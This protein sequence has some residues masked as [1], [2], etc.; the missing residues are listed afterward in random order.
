LPKGEGVLQLPQFYNIKCFIKMSNIYVIG[1]GIGG[2]AA[3]LRLRARG[4]N[5]TILEKCADAGGRARR[6]NVGG[7]IFDA[8]PTVITAPY[9]F[10]E[11]LALFNEK[12][13]DYVTIKPLSPIW[14]RYQYFDGTTLD[15]GEKD[16]FLAQIE[17][18]FPDD[19]AGYIA[20]YQFAEKIFELGYIDLSDQPFER[21]S[22]M[23]K[24]L[25]SILRL[26]GYKS[27]YGLVADY[28]KSPKL[29]QALC[30]AP[31]LLGGNPKTASAIYF[32]VHILEQRYGVHY[33]MGGTG[34]LVEALILLAKRQGINI[35]YNKNVCDMQIADGRI[36]T[37]LCEDGTSYNADRVVYNGDPAYLYRHI[38]ARNKQSLFTKI[39]SKYNAASMGL[40]VVYFVCKKSY[41]E[42]AHHTVGFSKSYELVLKDIFDKGKL[43]KDFSFYLHRPAATDPNAAKDGEDAFYVLVPVPNLKYKQWSEAEYAEYSEHIITQL[44]IRLLPELRSHLI[45]KH[46]ISPL[47]FRDALLSEHGSGFSLQPLLTQ[48]AW[49]RYHNQDARIK[50]LYLVGAG[51]HPG[52]GLPGVLNSAKIIEKAMS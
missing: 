19:K 49:F 1:A 30:T 40:L 43:S 35:E 15:Y 52:A 26:R 22:M 21:L 20:L 10:N 31:L 32:L 12:I 23:L 16:F 37:L 41:S 14:Y 51:T 13:E 39:K 34:A 7:Y 24:Q 5:V 28:I 46:H 38:I 27:V 25:P 9:L 6:F 3:A 44:E 17:S 47:Y 8:G 33:A 36:H 11:L 50:N 29:R 4:Y 42:I 45:A 48:S 18:Q 2:I